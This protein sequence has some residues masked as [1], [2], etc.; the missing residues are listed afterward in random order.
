MQLGHSVFGVVSFGNKPMIRKSILLLLAASIVSSCA[1][2]PGARIDDPSYE[3]DRLK[4][5]RELMT[6]RDF[7]SALLV[8]SN[9]PP[10]GPLASEAYYLK[11][12]S[13]FRLSRYAEAEV[14]YEDGYNHFKGPL[15]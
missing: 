5:A 14:A 1:I 4:E 8:L 15:T 7:D 9:L 12:D 11:G 2:G 3:K 10:A 13:Y 6:E